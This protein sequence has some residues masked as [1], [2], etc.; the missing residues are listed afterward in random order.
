[1]SYDWREALA[2]LE[3][4]GSR[5]SIWTSSCKNFH[6]SE[7]INSEQVVSGAAS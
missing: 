3:K 1:M 5:S 2:L 6:F 7:Q 4:V